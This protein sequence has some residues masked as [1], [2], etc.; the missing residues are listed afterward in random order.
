MK[1]AYTVFALTSSIAQAHHIKD[2]CCEFY[3]KPNFYG[4]MLAICENQSSHGYFSHLHIST[5]KSWKCGSRT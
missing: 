2:G 1:R 5:I 3:D 4:E